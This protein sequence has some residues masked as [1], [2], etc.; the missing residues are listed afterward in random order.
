M[1]KLQD[2]K[3]LGVT[4][5]STLCGDIVAQAVIKKVFGRLKIPLYG[6][7]AHIFPCSG[8]LQCHIVALLGLPILLLYYYL[9]RNTSK[10]AGS[11]KPALFRTCPPE[12]TFIVQLELNHLEFHNIN[13]KSG[14]N[15]YFTTCYKAFKIFHSTF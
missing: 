14:V 8:L 3:Y 5:D 6:H 4:I 10:S 9:A 7:D 12:T 2:N 13:D 11:T 1:I 15:I